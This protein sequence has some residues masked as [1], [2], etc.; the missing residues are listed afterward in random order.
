MIKLDLILGAGALKKIFTNI[1][2]IKRKEIKLGK[3]FIKEFEDKLV[4]VYTGKRHFSGDI[5]KSVISCLKE[6]RNMHNLIR[7]REIAKEMS[8]AL[9]KKDLD[10]FASLMNKET[11]ERRMLHKSV[12][13]EHL[14]KYI[15]K[16]F[17]NGAIAAKVCGSGGGGSILFFTDER[18]KLLKIF[19]KSVIDFKF[20]FGG[21]RWV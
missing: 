16:G 9:V 15:N 13:G 14:N 12:I 3:R 10:E 21:L 4:L 7:I 17:G 6:K 11:V 18:K 2:K 8:K 5:N 20:D 1:K 19:G